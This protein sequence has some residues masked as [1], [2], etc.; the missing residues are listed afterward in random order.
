MRSKSALSVGV[1]VITVAAVGFL[2]GCG[3]SPPA[4]DTSHTEAT[5]KGVVKINGV[6]ATE[7]DISF[8]PSN[9]QRKDVGARSAPIGPDGTYTIKTLTGENQVRIGGSLATKKPIAA[10][11]VHTVDVKDGENTFDFE[12]SEK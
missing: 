5:V 7:G 4:V 9:Y 8:D 1:G 6:P 3:G 2:A 11:T 10:R 12:A